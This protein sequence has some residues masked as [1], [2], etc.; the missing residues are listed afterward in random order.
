MDIPV[1]ETSAA[2]GWGVDA[3]EGMRFGAQGEAGRRPRLSSHVSHR[4][5]STSV[6]DRPRA[7][8]G[9]QRPVVKQAAKTRVIR[10]TMTPATEMQPP[11][12]DV[13]FV[14][15]DG[16]PVLPTV[17]TD[18]IEA[19]VRQGPKRHQKPRFRG[20]PTGYIRLQHRAM[21]QPDL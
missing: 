12:I 13:R 17:L 3:L 4:L 11:V 1:V 8:G 20:T 16:E 18:G 5:L 15:A 21:G 6:P 9:R 10:A 19:A 14:G 7:V 2:R